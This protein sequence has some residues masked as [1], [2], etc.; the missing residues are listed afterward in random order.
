MN[1][2]IYTFLHSSV[3]A[4]VTQRFDAHVENV[5]L[6]LVDAHVENVMLI[7]VDAHVENVM[8]I[9][10]G[11]NFLIMISV[12]FFLPSF[13]LLYYYF[14]SSL[15]LSALCPPYYIENIQY[16]GKKLWR[17][18]AHIWSSCALNFFRHCERI[19]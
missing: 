9:L 15:D 1:C 5:M 2:S 16:T 7:L 13:P 19:N 8:L 6:I 4:V 14:I 17:K 18:R 10:V 12:D 11:D 3:R